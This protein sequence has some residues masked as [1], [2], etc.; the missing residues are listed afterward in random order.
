MGV[1]GGECGDVGLWPPPKAAQQLQGAALPLQAAGHRLGVSLVGISLCVKR[2][3]WCALSSKHS[4]K[5]GQAAAIS[6]PL[7]P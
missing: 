1:W 4:E 7:S 3:G 2:L 6:F 5:R